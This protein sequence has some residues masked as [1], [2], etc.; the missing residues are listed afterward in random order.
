M[1]FEEYY[2]SDKNGKS[3]CI[4]RSLCKI[5]NREYEEV[6]NGLCDVAK[7]LNC[8]SFNDIPVFEKYME[9]NDIV[10]ISVSDSIKVKDLKIDS[11]SY[12]V[13]CYD[14]KDFYHM[15]SIVNNI[16]YDKNSDCM[17]LYVIAIY[18]KQK[19]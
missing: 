18:K 2:I 9:D 11:L 6:Y 16:I 5:L 8:S 7:E 13:F 1:K 14:K 17:D 15:I 10:K 19:N 3:N 12:A 4:V